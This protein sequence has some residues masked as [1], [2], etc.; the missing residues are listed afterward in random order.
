MTIQI[1]P[2][3]IVNLDKKQYLDGL[4]VEGK[5]S[6]G[7]QC[8][9]AGLHTL[10][11][12]LTTMRRP[13]HSLKIFGSW[14]GDRIVTITP[15]TDHPM[16]DPLV[17]HPDNPLAQVCNSG[18][19]YDFVRDATWPP[20]PNLGG[21]I[22]KL[23]RDIT[24]EVVEALL[25]NPT[26]NAN[27]NPHTIGK[28]ID[29]DLIEGILLAPNLHWVNKPF[30]RNFLKDSNRRDRFETRMMYKYAIS[31]TSAVLYVE[32]LLWT[33]ELKTAGFS[34]TEIVEWVAKNGDWSIRRI[35]Q[36]IDELEDHKLLKSRYTGTTTE[37]LIRDLT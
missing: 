24:D 22:P 2:R 16:L 23:Y 27:P 29:L 37:Y 1:Q 26:L 11:N 14:A 12:I 4:L 36:L 33:A 17:L 34:V 10:L 35:D 8:F 18:E 21:K 28:T 5:R 6:F 9:S 19:L 25:I 31:H 20:S 13:D 32:L 30:C 7:E 3:M 15:T